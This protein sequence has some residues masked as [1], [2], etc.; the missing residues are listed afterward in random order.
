M[1][2]QVTCEININKTPPENFSHVERIT[3]GTMLAIETKNLSRTC[4][5]ESA[6]PANV[7]PIA[8]TKGKILPM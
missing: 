8:T 6:T 3:T 1:S 2:T 5:L 4:P 7:A